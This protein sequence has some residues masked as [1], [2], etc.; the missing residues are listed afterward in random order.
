MADYAASVLSK[1]QVMYNQ[2]MNQAEMRE[3]PSATLMTLRKNTQF[4]IPDIKELREREDRATSA[5]MKNRSSRALGSARTFDHNGTVSDST[6]V[7]ILFDTYSD[8]FSTSLKRGD[9]NVFS[10]AEMLSHEIENAFINLHEGIETALVTW[11][12][13]N[14]TTAGA[15]TKRVA[16]GAFNVVNAAYDIASGDANE[17]WHIIK[18]IFRQDKF[19][20][21]N[22]D[23]ITDSFLASTGDFKAQQGQGN[24]TNL[25]FQF[26]GLNV[27]ESIEVSDASYANGISFAMPAGMTGIID[28][29]PKQNRAGKGN[30]DSVLGG[31]STITDPLT[32]LTMAIHGYTEREDTSGANG[33]GQDEVTQWEISVDLS[34][35]HAQIPTA[36][37]GVTSPILAIGQL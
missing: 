33:N 36:G 11:L 10:D 17:Y 6:E 24:S 9:N 37:S 21:T 8:K 3:K 27:M 26:S 29:I 34:P 23:I 20:G 19:S 16:G 2:R 30:F 15:A 31:Y 4:L 32:G 5:Y 12:D 22:I 14:K 7:P 1:A 18:S 35:Q 25:G 28:W 13:A